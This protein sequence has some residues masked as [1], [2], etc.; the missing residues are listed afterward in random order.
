MAAIGFL[1]VVTS[2]AFA[3]NRQ[4]SSAAGESRPEGQ[5]TKFLDPI[6]AIAIDPARGPR[7]GT[8]LDLALSG[9]REVLVADPDHHRLLRYNP[10]THLLEL[11][12]VAFDKTLPSY[13]SGIAI[14]AS[15]RIIVANQ[16]SHELLVFDQ[17][18]RLLG[19]IGGNGSPLE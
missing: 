19:A 7:L 11:L 1:L 6:R 4:A 8:H 18:G 12:P 10:N 15:G 17:T 2:L 16:D 13:P 9:D 3:G 14:D 5:S